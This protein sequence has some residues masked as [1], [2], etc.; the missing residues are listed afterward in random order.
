MSRLVVL[1]ITHWWYIASGLTVVLLVFVLMAMPE[2]NQ[3]HLQEVRGPE[4]QRCF[5][6]VASQVPD[7]SQN[8]S[9]GSVFAI[10]AVDDNRP[11]ARAGIRPGDVPVGYQHGMAAGFYGDLEAALTGY[12]VT[13]NVLSISDW[14]RGRDGWRVIR[15]KGLA[16]L[17]K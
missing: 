8:P 13:L 17:C 15:L 11:L 12:E 5:G 6:F 2:W 16:G 9:V 1:R 4:L 7:P 3:T 10:I 14:Q